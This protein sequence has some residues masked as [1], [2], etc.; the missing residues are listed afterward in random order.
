MSI[1][2][3]S[4]RIQLQRARLLVLPLLSAGMGAEARDRLLLLPLQ[5][6]LVLGVVGSQYV[7]VMVD[8]S[9]V[10]IDVDVRDI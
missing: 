5:L 2:I 3:P 7:S 8:C 10:R 9:T 6:L 1:P 4:Y